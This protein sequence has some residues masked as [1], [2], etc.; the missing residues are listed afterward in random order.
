MTDDQLSKRCSVTAINKALEG[1]RGPGY[2]DPPKKVV[3]FDKYK[4]LSRHQVDQGVIALVH[5]CNLSGGSVL[6]M[7]LYK[8]VRTYLWSQEARDAINNVVV[9]H[10]L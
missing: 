7:D 4:K 10:D 1:Y 9:C 6:D 5:A 8:L 3:K 2:V